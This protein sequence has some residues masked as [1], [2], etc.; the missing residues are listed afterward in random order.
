MI[1][2]LVKSTLLLGLLYVVY[3]LLLENEKI[4]RFNRFFLLFALVFGLT[5]PLIS[6]EV[7]PEQSIAG[8]KMQQMERVINAPAEAVNRTMEPLI[9]PNQDISSGSEITPTTGNRSNW[10]IGALELIFGLYGAITLFLFIRFVVGLIEIRNKVKAGSHQKTDHATLV[11]LDEPITPQSFLG[12]IFLEKKQFHSGEIEPEIL[13]HEITHI[14]QLHSLDVLIIEFLKVIFWFNPLMYLFKHA[15]QLNHEFLADESVV[16]NGSPIKN[17]QELLI[18]V[19]SG[20]TS[21]KTTSHIDFSLTKKRFKMML[22]HY[23]PIRSYSIK[24]ILFPVLL[25]V[26]IM[27]CTRQ[28]DYPIKITGNNDLLYSTVDLYVNPPR[29]E[30]L[31]IER[32]GMGIRYDSKGNPYTG[33][34]QF[35]YVKNDSLFSE[36][37][38]EGGIMKSSVGYDKSGNALVRFEYSYIGDQYKM[39]K[40]IKPNGFI[41]EEWKDAESNELGYH[42]QW[43]PNSQLKYE[44]YFE[45]NTEYEGLMTLYNETGEIIKQQLYKDGEMIETLK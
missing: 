23:S 44:A 41:V 25:I 18:K 42:K 21:L 38:Y 2:Y 22:K 20:N 12:Y 40:Q 33:T 3:K 17:Y 28:P 24:M 31:N 35:K 6:F 36:V 15:I 1:I 26:T 27:F 5:A 10:S 34:Q 13:D 32:R 4:H 19:S 16:S 45:G 14:R 43:H 11:L 29:S 7:P 39:V 9:S 37:K 8:I 30:E